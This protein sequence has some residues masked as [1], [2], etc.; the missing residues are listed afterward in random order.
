[1]ELVALI[2]LLNRCYYYNLL[3]LFKKKI[4]AKPNKI[5]L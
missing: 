3:L 1:M 2:Q 4:K 5:D